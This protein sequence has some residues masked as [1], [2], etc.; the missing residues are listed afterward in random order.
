MSMYLLIVPFS[1]FHISELYE[2][3][4]NVFNR[5]STLHLVINKAI[6][7]TDAYW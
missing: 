5:Y 6:L 2:M 4:D 3:S 7:Q 1:D